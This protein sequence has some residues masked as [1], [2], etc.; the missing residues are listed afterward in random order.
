MEGKEMLDYFHDSLCIQFRCCEEDICNYITQTIYAIVI[1]K[2]MGPGSPRLHKLGKALLQVDFEYD[3]EELYCV[4]MMV[5]I[6]F[7]QKL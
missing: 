4:L 1:H 5:T 2:K 3:A 6:L 7:P